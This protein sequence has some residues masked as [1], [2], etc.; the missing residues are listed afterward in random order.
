MPNDTVQD[1][2]LNRADGPAVGTSLPPTSE[3]ERSRGAVGI[4][5][6]VCASIFIS[7]LNASIVNV[8]LPSIGADLEVDAALLG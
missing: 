6:V 3:G 1:G 2:A 8:V 7:V 5:I 4:L